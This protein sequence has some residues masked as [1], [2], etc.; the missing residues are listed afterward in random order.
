MEKFAFCIS[1]CHMKRPGVKFTNGPSAMGIF[2]LVCATA[3][4]A[5]RFFRLE[6]TG[7]LSTLS[8]L[9]GQALEPECPGPDPGPASCVWTLSELNFSVPQFL[10]L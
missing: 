8:G 10:C 3:N 1:V 2:I 7:L 4:A 6:L 5:L 9:R